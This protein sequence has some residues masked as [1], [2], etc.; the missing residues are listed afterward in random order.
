MTFMLQ[1]Q[2]LT[3]YTR[4]PPAQLSCHFS[5][6]FLLKQ[7]HIMHQLHQAWPKRKHISLSTSFYTHPHI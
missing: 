1:N 5:L 7:C 4:F 6:T 2:L 3:G